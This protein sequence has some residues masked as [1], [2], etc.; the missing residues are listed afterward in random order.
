MTWFKLAAEGAFHPKVVKAGNEAYGAWCRAGQWSSQYLTD[1]VVPWDVALRI[2]PK[3]LWKKL[4][5]VGLVEAREGEAP[6]GIHDFHVYNPKASAVL[7][8]RERKAKNIRDFRE[9]QRQREAGAVA[10]GASAHVTGYG[11]GHTGPVQPDTNH[12]PDPDPDPDQ[13]IPLTPLVA[14]EPVTPMIGQPSQGTLQAL[15]TAYAHGI[16]D[17]AG[18]PWRMPDANYETPII[19]EAVAT[20]RPNLTREEWPRWVRRSAA[21]YR[22]MM[23]GKAEFQ[24]GFRP[25]KWLEWLNAGGERMRLNG[26]A[27]GH[28]QHD[29][30]IP[31][32]EPTAEEK[33]ALRKEAE[34]QRE[35]QRLQREAV[36]KGK[37]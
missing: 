2:G 37:R 16:A 24:K 10:N 22:R 4:Q 21:T 6:V 1:G 3:K 33:A 7:A 5:E 30:I 20:H 18:A 26:T 15:A 34:E 25:S 23:A 35:R 27:N 13:K 32:R 36:E 8:E 28:A 31:S 29:A 12:G 17:A 9:R 19:V 14:G 11:N